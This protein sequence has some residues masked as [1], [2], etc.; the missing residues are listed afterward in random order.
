MTL[1]TIS[2]LV[3]ALFLLTPTG[4]FG[5]P[6]F[7]GQVIDAETN[8]PLGGAIIVVVWRKTVRLSMEGRQVLHEVAEA[9]TDAEGRFSVEDNPSW[10]LNPL[11]QL[12]PYPEI[13]IFHPGYA[14]FPGSWDSIRVRKQS[15]R[16]E[17]MNWSE[18]IE[19]LRRG[20][21]VR[22]GKLT[23]REDFA[24]YSTPA[25]VVVGGAPPQ[26]IPRLMKALDEHRTAAGFPPRAR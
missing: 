11:T 13:G 9:V 22:L 12:D 1:T 2:S 8:E 24:R 25:A 4:A 5:G 7:H 26:T 14:A 23:S 19:V 20:M 18:R 3:L 17:E 15:G 16:I 6:P 10:N 21:I